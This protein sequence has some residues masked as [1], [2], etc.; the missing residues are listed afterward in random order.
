MNNLSKD[1]REVGI[2]FGG[3]AGQWVDFFLSRSYVNV[4]I[5]SVLSS[6]KM[7]KGIQRSSYLTV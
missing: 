4:V 5:F 6:L 3:G 1:G 2:W 7:S